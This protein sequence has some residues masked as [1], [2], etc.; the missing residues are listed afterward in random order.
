MPEL[1]N[2]VNWVDIISLILLLRIAYVSS[3][4]GVG[5]QILPLALLILTLVVTLY[6]YKGIATFFVER[7]SLSGAICSFFSFALLA[8][9]FSGIYRLIFRLLSMFL[10]AGE[11]N[12]GGIE[13]VGGA[14]LG[15]MRS[16]II[17]GVLLIVLILT[18]VGFVDGSVKN[19]Y[20]G[21]FFIIT[22]VKI[23]SSIINFFFTK[24]K[25]KPDRVLSELTAKKD[26]YILKSF[27][28][29]KKTR[30]FKE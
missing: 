30:F 8:L 12:V 28:F 13:K 27:D 20:S 23:Y 21:R 19:S 2:K 10:A 3:R 22:N 18:P 14:I 29:R 17:I 6:N 7:F 4:V 26:T 24:Q 1:I 9:I 11:V 5:I 15:L 16:S 25:V